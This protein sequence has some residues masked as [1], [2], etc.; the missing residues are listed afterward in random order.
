MKEPVEGEVITIK[1][2]DTLW[3]LARKYLNNPTKWPEFKKYNKFTN[4][5]RIYPGENMQLPVKAAKAIVKEATKE[6]EVRSSEVGDAMK[7]LQNSNEK[8]SKTLQA[9]IEELEALKKAVKLLSEEISR[10]ENKVASLDNRLSQAETAVKDEFQRSN[11]QVNQLNEKVDTIDENVR[12]MGG[13][14]DQLAM[15][16]QKITQSVETLTVKVS[17]LEK[18]KI[19]EPEIEKPS[20]GKKAFAVFTVLAGSIAWFVVSALS[21]SD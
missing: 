17:E 1:K 13:K 20:H 16:G 10:V 9:Q 21:H 19:A 18:M 6:I 15:D 14:V 8:M 3:H 2:G 4:P 11:K 12:A 7:A 5:N